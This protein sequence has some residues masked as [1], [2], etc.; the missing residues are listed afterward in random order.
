MTEINKH[1]SDWTQEELKALPFRGDYDTPVECD[2]LIILPTR[3][4]HSSGFRCMD[5]VAVKG[6]TPICRVSGYSDVLH[7][8]GIGGIGIWKG[9][10]P[11]L[12]KAKGWSIDCLQKSGL[13]RLFSAKY[14]LIVGN[15]LS[16]M[17]IF[18]KE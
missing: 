7:I 11:D 6:N 18:A 8:D 10:I 9:S 1:F 3:R 2:S 17:E 4:K 16:S 5:F 14:K 13:L 15:A 12:I